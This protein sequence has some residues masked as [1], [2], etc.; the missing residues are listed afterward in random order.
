MERI[1]KGQVVLGV[2]VKGR[3]EGRGGEER[4]ESWSANM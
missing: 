3:S 2:V 1:M 4:R